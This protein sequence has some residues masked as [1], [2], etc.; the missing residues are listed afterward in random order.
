VAPYLFCFGFGYT[1]HVLARRLAAAG[2]RVG[3]T[4]RT[5]ETAAAAEVAAMPF[6]RE[7]PLPPD[8]LA[9]VTHILSSIPPDM[10][11][12]PVLDRHGADIAA[13]PD[14]VWVGYLSTTGVYGDRGGAWVDETSPLAPTGER[15]RRRA[16]A[17]EGWL[18]LWRMRRVPVHVFRLAA[19]YGPGRNPFAALRAG[20]A[21]R[22]DRPGQVFSRI[23]VEDLAAAL[24]ASIARP[25][26]GAV[27]NI[28][29]DEPA[30]PA[31]VVAHAARLL[32]LP[33][34][35][36][37]PFAAAELSPLARS[38]YADNKRVSNAL[39]KRE[40]GVRLRYPDYRVGLAAIRA[41][42]FSQNCLKCRTDLPEP[43]PSG[44]VGRDDPDHSTR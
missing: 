44:M 33:P 4:C 3:G 43:A 19:I 6:E 35:P 20:T 42:E 37:V 18:T 25:R 40:L 28:C 9:G 32:G 22:I 1:A 38:F 29:D 36:L 30:S 11:G 15:G 23:H 10:E 16:A 12:D 7:R 34:P 2:W 39:L 17:E 27:Y 8:A 14:L 41:A 13:L 5:S 24:S 21:K 26:P 31:A